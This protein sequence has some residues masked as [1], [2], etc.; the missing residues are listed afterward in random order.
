MSPLNRSQ[1]KFLRHDTIG[2]E[3]AEQ[4]TE[5]LKECFVDTGDLAVLRN[6]REPRR[7]VVGRTGAGKSALLL[8]LAKVEQ[9][10]ASIEPEQLALN[11][12]ANSTILR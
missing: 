4:D 8:L 3:G 1:F 2:T 7:I 5:Y 9:R 11:Y 10:V 6:T 12:I